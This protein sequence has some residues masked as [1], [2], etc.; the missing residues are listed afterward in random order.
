[1]Y[2]TIVLDKSTFQLLNYMELYRLSCY[3]KHIVTPVLTL[4]ILGDLSKEQK[5]GRPPPEDRV[6]DFSKKL[7]TN[8]TIVNQSV[9][10]IVL[11]DLTG[12]RIPLDRRPIVD[13]EKTTSKGSDVGFK[14]KESTEESAINK[15][16]Q[17]NF[18]EAEQELSAEW[19]RTTSEP[20]ILDRLKKTLN[21]KKL[22]LK[23]IEELH[24]YVISILDDPNFQENLL[25]A[26]FQNYDISAGQGVSI[27]S[28]WNQENRPLI[29][30]FS[31]YTYHCIKVDLMFLIGLSE[32]LI[33]TRSTNTVDLQYLYYLPFCKIFSSNDKIHKKLVPVLLNEDQI[34]I[35]GPELKADFKTMLEHIDSLPEEDRVKYYNKPPINAESFTFKLWKEV[36][37]YTVND[38][39]WNREISEDEKKE[40]VS[41]ME[42]ILSAVETGS[43]EDLDISDADFL[44]KTSYVQK[45]D[46]CFCGSGKKITE[47]HMTEKEFRKQERL[48]F[49]KEILNG[50]IKPN[51]KDGN[52]P[53]KEDLIKLIGMIENDEV[54]IDDLES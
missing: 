41:H 10:K 34:F 5:E 17:G 32:E 6:I 44:V 47:C 16:K 22:G 12:G 15:W 27:M 24:D 23:N 30:D 14:V 36:F 33:G 25:I 53:S 45:D 9:K 19:R 54:D 42:K 29:K 7:F 18:T 28:K 38:H 4:E 46:P 52:P 3:Y 37:G 20:E 39:L 40:S 2:L 35:E 21:Y 43:E 11:M 1:M 49:L 48:S 31:P 26:T 50:T 51:M 13:V 8:K